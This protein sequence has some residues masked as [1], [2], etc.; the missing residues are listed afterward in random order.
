[1]PSLL[2]PNLP[3]CRPPVIGGIKPAL[4][5]MANE[6]FE[7]GRELT[8]A[9]KRQVDAAKSDKS[10]P[11]QQICVRDVCACKCVSLCI[12]CLCVFFCVCV[13]VSFLGWYSC[14]IMYIQC[15][16]DAVNLSVIVGITRG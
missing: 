1:M 11:I 16:G 10:L 14:V 2:A 4:D 9:F 5:R 6:R 7:L 12:L 8:G 3:A 15:N 13:C